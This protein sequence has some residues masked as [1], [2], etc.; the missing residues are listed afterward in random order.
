MP[1]YGH[2]KGTEQKSYTF[3]T[4]EAF[5]IHEE[6]VTSTFQEFTLKT[7]KR[8]MY[9]LHYTSSYICM[10]N[11]QIPNISGH[12]PWLPFIP[13]DDKQD[14]RHLPFVVASFFNEAGFHPLLFCILYY[15]I[16]DYQR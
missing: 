16:S 10:M 9:S 11:L 4:P 2:L 12:L 15:F 14:S 6:Q 13:S 7:V 5:L 8:L 3:L 1:K